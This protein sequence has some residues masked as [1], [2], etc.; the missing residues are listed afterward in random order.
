MITLTA[1][2]G[3]IRLT[4]DVRRLGRDLNVSLYG[5]DAAHIGAV[6]LAEPRPSL[7]GDGGV[8][9]SCSVL[10]RCGHKEDQ[11]ARHAALTLAARLN[12]VVCV[13]CGIHIDGIAPEEISVVLELAEEMLDKLPDKLP[14]KLPDKLP[15]AFDD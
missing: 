13:A 5:G 14:G 3:R 15:D 12:A 11:L 4:L 2:R 8:S 7:R 10:T 9:A 1:S 6:A